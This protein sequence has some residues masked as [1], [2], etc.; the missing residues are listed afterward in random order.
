MKLFSNLKGDLQGGISAAAVSIPQCLGYG[1]IAFASLGPAFAAQAAV[2]GFYAAIFA[3]FASPCGS[4][5]IQIN[6]PKAPVTIILASAVAALASD[7]HLATLPAIERETLIVGLTATMVLLGGLF[8]VTFGKLR[9]GTII[10]YIPY[11]VVSGFMNGIAIILI[12][13]QISVVLGFQ[14]TVSYAEILAH[15]TSIKILSVIVGLATLIAI[16]LT[17][18]FLKKIPGPLA[19]LIVGTFFYYAFFAL[20]GSASLGPVLGT[21]GGKLPWPEAFLELPDVSGVGIIWTFLPLLSITALVLAAVGSMDTLLSSVASDN[22]TGFRHNSNKE[23]VG[24]GLGNILGSLFGAIYSAGSLP[25]S[26]VNFKAGGR[27]PL[28]GVICSFVLLLV[29]TILSPLVGKIPLVVLGAI[30]IY[31]GISLFDIW[32]I[33]LLRK[34]MAK[35]RYRKNITFFNLK[36]ILIEI[37]IIAVVTIITVSVNLILAVGAGVFIASVMFM[38]KM[39]KSVIRRKYSGDRI[40]S[41]KVRNGNETGILEKEGGKIGVFELSGSLF[42]GSAESLAREI[43][44]SL[45]KFT[46]FIL[47]MKRLNNIDSTGA[48]IILQINNILNREGKHLLISYAKARDELWEFLTV[49]DIIKAMGVDSFFSD[50]DIALEWAEEHLLAH[51]G[52]P[53]DGHLQ[54]PLESMEITRGFKP[55]ELEALKNRLVRQTYA[56]GEIILRE[57]EEAS[58]LCLLTKGA[59]SVRISLPRSDRFKRLATLAPGAI[60][61]EMAFLDGNPR[62]ADVWAEEDCEIL[63]LPLKDL[64]EFTREMPE[65]AFKMMQNIA[66]ILS[67]RLR[68]TSI[69]VGVLEDS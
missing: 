18:R 29:V 40:H 58:D 66:K 19:A 44:K 69:E 14:H 60:F 61:G 7:T 17:R 39:R 33:G 46:Y 56:K 20:A 27:T 24:Q 59:A 57:G 41:K 43:D 26:M 34:M 51:L 55:D 52:N 45:K 3:G 11:P 8:Q 2:L 12:K 1:L 49:M 10:K 30:I 32:T 15:L 65:A 28:A 53:K 9:F 4:N 47:D 62:S 37:M 50:T 31:I 68:R 22:L 35:M 63:R 42:F 6:G 25:R 36:D 5:P 67:R 38:G 21:L 16:F 13:G 23:L 54:V 48:H 64:D